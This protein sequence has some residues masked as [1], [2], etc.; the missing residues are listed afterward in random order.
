[1]AATPTK[2]LAALRRDRDDLGG[3]IA[4]QL[5]AID[6]ELYDPAR[7]EYSPATR[8]YTLVHDL[9]TY[10]GLLARMPDA[11]ARAIIYSA[12][13][14]SLRQRGWRASLVLEQEPGFRPG[15]PP[16]RAP[17]AARIAVSWDSDE[18]T[19]A[20]IRAMGAIISPG[21]ARTGG[22][23]GARAGGGPGGARAG[24]GQGDGRGRGSDAALDDPA[25]RRLFG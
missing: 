15:A 20:E 18:P 10:D 13:L 4:Q 17:R 25:I 3:N 22:P 6:E 5:R 8:T 2:V 7:H 14:D 24:G 12:V 23:G 16:L 11:R 19:D 1:M 21:S 9:P